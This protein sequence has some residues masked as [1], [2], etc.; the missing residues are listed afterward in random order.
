MFFSYPDLIIN[1]SKR[2]IRHGYPYLHFFTCK[3][4]THISQEGDAFETIPD[5]TIIVSRVATKQNKSQYYINSRSSS[6]TEVTDLLRRR[7]IDLDH[8]RFLILQV[9][10]IVLLTFWGSFG[11]ILCLSIPCG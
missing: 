6:Y 1:F 4:S 8:N 10:V 7:G 5:T 3:P 9:R 11:V 2:S